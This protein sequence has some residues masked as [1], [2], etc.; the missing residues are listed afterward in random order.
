MIMTVTLDKL[1]RIVI[2]NSVRDKMQLAAGDDLELESS[3]DRIVLHPLRGR[4]R[5]RK[6]QGMWVFHGGGA[7][8]AATVR[9][10]IEQIRRERDM[11]NSGLSR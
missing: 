9:R 11:R 1:G 5:L 3:D 2:P 7:L 6:E 4:G 8:S 10:T